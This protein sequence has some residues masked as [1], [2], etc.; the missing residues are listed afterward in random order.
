MK[1][2]E[3]NVSKSVLGIGRISQGA[4]LTGLQGKGLCLQY[5][6]TRHDTTQHN[7][8]QHDTTQLSGSIPTVWW[9]LLCSKIT[10]SGKNSWNRAWK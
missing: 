1:Y 4:L 5:N 2:A 3:P 10:D 9:R 6:T 7:T 8:I